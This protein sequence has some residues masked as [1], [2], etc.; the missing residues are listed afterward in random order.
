[1]SLWKREKPG[2]SSIDPIEIVP[3]DR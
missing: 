1:M 3:D 2:S